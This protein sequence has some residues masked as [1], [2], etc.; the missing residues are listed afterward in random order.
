VVYLYSAKAHET[1]ILVAVQYVCSF[2]DVAKAEYKGRI[3]HPRTDFK[4]RILSRPAMTFWD[5]VWREANFFRIHLISFVLVPLIFSGIFYASNG[6]F[7]IRFID[8]LFLCYSSM[9]DTGLSTVNLSTLTAWQQVI[10]YLLMS[11]VSVMYV[12]RFIQLVEKCRAIL[13]LSHG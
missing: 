3:Q 12:S 6:R 4:P 8:A 10:L 2:L 9:T 7:H 1:L 11:L 13:L 5:V